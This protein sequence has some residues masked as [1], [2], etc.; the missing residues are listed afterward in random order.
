M[1]HVHRTLN[2]GNQVVVNS[3][4]APS[5]SFSSFLCAARKLT[6]T[7]YTATS[8]TL[9]CQRLTTIAG[10]WV[11]HLYWFPKSATLLRR[12]FIKAYSNHLREI[13]Y[14]RKRF[15]YGQFLLFAGSLDTYIQQ[16]VTD[17]QNIC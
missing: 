11:C 7:E 10:L 15:R 6:T 9:P 1:A 16:N 14:D 13:L 2:S 8:P 3:V 12:I 17:T 5:H 4:C